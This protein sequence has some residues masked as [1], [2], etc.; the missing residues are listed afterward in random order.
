MLKKYLKKAK[1]EGW[2]IPQFN[3]ST[4][5]QLRAIK[6]ASKELNSPVIV[7]TSESEADFFGFD[8]AVA[9]VKTYQKNGVK[10]YLNLDHGGSFEKCKKAIDTG[11]DSVHFDGSKLGFLENL[12]ITKQ[13][14]A[15]A[16][17]INKEISVEGELGVITNADD[18]DKGGKIKLTDIKEVEEFSQKT[19][20]DRLAISIGTVH[21]VSL[22]EQSIDFSVL[23]KINSKTDSGLVLH[24]GS[25]VNDEDIKSVIKYGIIKININTELRQVF[26]MGLREL[27]AKDEKEIKP[28]NYYNKAIKNTTKIVEAKIQL[29]G[30]YNKI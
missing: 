22:K 14:V 30:S 3:F 20:I 27:L 28:Y 29:F 15:Y 23:Q 19:K 8:E 6:N 4:L 26:V 16:Q 17:K 13:V 1:K 5:E 25:G 18:F 7:A 24:G 21:G 10:I 11:Y 12:A 9:I 2:A